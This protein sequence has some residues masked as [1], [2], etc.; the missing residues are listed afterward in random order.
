MSSRTS[1][2]R[3]VEVAQ[4]PVVIAHYLRDDGVIPNNQK[5]PLLIYKGSLRLPEEEPA[6]AIEQLLQKNRWGASWRNGIY[7]YHHYHS[8]AHEVLLVLAGTAKVQLG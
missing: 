3:A 1:R 4:K 2:Q 6:E 8:T 5:L 7:T